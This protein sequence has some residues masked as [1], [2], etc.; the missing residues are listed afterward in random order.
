[1]SKHNDVSSFETVTAHNA[2][3]LVFQHPASSTVL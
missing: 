3:L 2:L 1:M